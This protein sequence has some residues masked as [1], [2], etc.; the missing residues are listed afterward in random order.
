MLKISEIP[1]RKDS[2]RISDSKVTMS[3][4]GFSDEKG[5]PSVQKL[6]ALGKSRC[7]FNY[8]HTDFVVRVPLLA[9]AVGDWIDDVDFEKICWGGV[10]VVQRLLLDV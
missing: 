9:D 5:R 2:H 3:H 10:C 1:V 4:H 8:L 6:T 7:G